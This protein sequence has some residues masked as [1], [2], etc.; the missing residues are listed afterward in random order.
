MY[1]PHETPVEMLVPEVISSMGYSQFSGM[2]HQR[3]LVSVAQAMGLDTD[4]IGIGH[5]RGQRGD[6]V[7]CSGPLPGLV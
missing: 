3:F 5:T 7:D 4:H 1:W 6:I 2:P